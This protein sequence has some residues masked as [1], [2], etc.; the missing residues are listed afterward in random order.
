MHVERVAAGRPVRPPAAGQHVP[1]HDRA[2]PFDERVREPRLH[3]GQAD[4]R[5]LEAQHAVAVEVRDRETVRRGASSEALDP[6]VD[7]GLVG[8]DA[9]PVLDAVGDRRRGHVPLDQ[10]Q[11]G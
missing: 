5:A 7:V 11:P 1:P 9:H 3:R 2:E 8:G 4:P 6:S 10:Q